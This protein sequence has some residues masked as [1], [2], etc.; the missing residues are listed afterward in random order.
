MPVGIRVAAAPGT[1]PRSDLGPRSLHDEVVEAALVF[2]GSI[3]DEIPAGLA[4]AERASGRLAAVPASKALG[5]H[6]NPP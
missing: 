1:E 4:L 6:L 3:T 2:A 5:K